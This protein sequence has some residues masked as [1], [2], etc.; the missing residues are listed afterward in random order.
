MKN[1][2]NIEIIVAIIS[3]IVVAYSIILFSINDV[4]EY[5]VAGAIYE[6]TWLPMIALIHLLPLANLFVWIRSKFSIK[7]F[8]LYGFLATT[9]NVLNLHFN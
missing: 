7:S 1:Q 5:A 6:I 2:K 3:L 4:Y 8:C 9:L